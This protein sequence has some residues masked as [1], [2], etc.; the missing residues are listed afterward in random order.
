MYLFFETKLF[1]YL[2]IFIVV[3]IELILLKKEK[4][5]LNFNF[6]KDF[7]FILTF[8]LSSI[9]ILNCI[10]ALFKFELVTQL[11]LIPLHILCLILFAIKTLNG[12]ENIFA[13][14]FSNLFNK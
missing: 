1:A 3:V 9:I 10:I 7:S 12:K 6:L 4:K 8:I 5:K 11:R 14:K 2:G 13:N